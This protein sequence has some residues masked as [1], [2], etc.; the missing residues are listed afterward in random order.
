MSA[1]SLPIVQSASIMLD[2]VIWHVDDGTGRDEKYVVTV[3]TQ[4]ETSESKNEENELQGYGIAQGE[5]ETGHDDK[6]LLLNT[7]DTEHSRRNL[8]HV[9]SNTHVYS[10]ASAVESLHF[11]FMVRHC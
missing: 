7:D 1:R 8:Q 5:R 10:R 9:A 11:R 2:R 4:N 3:E 6:R